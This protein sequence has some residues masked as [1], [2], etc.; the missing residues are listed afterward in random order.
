MDAAFPGDILSVENGAVDINS[1]GSGQSFALISVEAGGNLTESVTGDFTLG[2]SASTLRVN[3]NLTFN[4]FEAGA[5][6]TLAA[7]V[8]GSGNMDFNSNGAG[9]ELILSRLG[10]HTGTVRFNGTG[11]TVRL[12]GPES[13][14]IIEMNSTGANTFSYEPTS[15]GQVN[16]GSVIFNQDGTLDHATNT[17]RLQGGTLSLVANAPVTVDLTK[18]FTGNERRMLIADEQGS[19]IG[20]LQGSGNVTV[21]GTTTAPAFGDITR[22]EFEIGGTGPEP[23]SEFTD[24]YSGTVTVNDYV[25]MEVRHNLPN[26]RIVVNNNALLDMGHQVVAAT[27]SIKIGAVEV[28]SGGILEVGFEQSS[29]TNDGHHAYHLTLTAAGSRDGD[30]TLHD[31]ATTRMQINGTGAGQFDTITA[32]GTVAL[33][34]TLDVL[35]N[36]VASS[37]TNPTY[38]PTM[39]G[40]LFDIITITATTPA[41]DYNQSGTVGPEDYDLWRS[42]FGNTIA[43]GTAADGNGNGVIDAGDYVIWRKNNGQTGGVVG[44]VSGTFDALNIVDPG[45]TLAGIGATMQVVY[46]SSTLVQLQ[47]VALGSGASLAGAVPEPGTIALVGL[48][49]PV[50]LFS[51]RGRSNA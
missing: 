23:A 16:G 43:A 27:Q 31:G 50:L 37:G 12:Q 20:H 35:I 51:R 18:F 22:N 44:S 3:R 36:P 24:S 49:L 4:G 28:N 42:T 17:D 33:N 9:S 26:A 21:N 39:V 10:G 46:A 29:S 48:V 15:G 5:K 2:T 6:F 47:V 34:G 25:N 14:S 7:D 30:L 41:G 11:D 45:G 13:F 8:T 19:V 40:D 1:G 38:S 32:Q